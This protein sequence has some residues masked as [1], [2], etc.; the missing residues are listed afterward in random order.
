MARLKWIEEN[1]GMVVNGGS[2]LWWT[3]QVEDGFKKVQKGEKY[4]I[5]N[6]NVMLSKQ[7]AELVYETRNKLSNQQRKKV[8][9]L[10]IIG[11]CLCVCMFVCVCGHICMYVYTYTYI[12]THA[13]TRTHTHTHTDVHARD[14]I[15]GFVRDSILD[16]REFAWES[17][18]RFYWIRTED[19]LFA[20]QCTF[21]TLFGYEYMVRV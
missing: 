7:L 15:D 3:W 20:K 9:T 4:A 6:L 19:D 13:H 16:E 12:H 17:Q 18:L 10:I 2:K 21:K 8:N 1:I 14:I 5:K 11:L